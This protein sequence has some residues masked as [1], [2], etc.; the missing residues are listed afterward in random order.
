MTSNDATQPM[1]K[2]VQIDQRI[3]DAAM[4]AV[5]RERARQGG[6][7]E[8]G[9]QSIEEFTAGFTSPNVTSGYRV[10]IV[11]LDRAEDESPAN[12]SEKAAD[13]ARQPS[14]DEGTDVK[15]ETDEQETSG[16]DILVDESEETGSQTLEP[17]TQEQSGNE[18]RPEAA[19]LHPDEEGSPNLAPEEVN[20][21]FLDAF[22]AELQRCG[23]VD[24]V[25]SPGSRSTG[26][27]MKAY[28]RFHDVYVHVDER[29][30]AFFALG[31][32]KAKRRPV[33][34]ICTSGTAVGNWMP[35]VLEA[36]SSRVPL[37][38]LS[39]DRPA[40]LQH[41]GSPQTCDQL[42]MF[43]SHVR[44]FIQMPEPSADPTILSY[45]RQMA[46]EACIA[47]HGAVP[48]MQSC[49]AGPVHLNFPFDE[50][51]IPAAK[52][53]DD[54]AN[55]LPPTVVAGQ[56]LY[57]ADVKGIRKVLA[58]R[59]TIAL[60]GEGSINSPEDAEVLLEFARELHIPLIADP[61]S[62]LRSYGDPLVLDAYG[63]MDSN[64]IPAADVVIRFGRWP[65]SKM[66][67]R[68]LADQ[69][70]VHIAVDVRDTR[71]MTSSTSLFV[72]T[73]PVVFATA[74]RDASSE[75]AADEAGCAEWVEANERA[76][77]RI[78][79]SIRPQRDDFEGAYVAKTLELAPE[80]SLVFCANSMS[81]R[82][83]DR[84]YRKGGKNLRVLCNRGLNGIDGTLSSAIGAS[85]AYR[86]ATF[87]TGDLALLHDVNA[88]AFQNELRVREMHGGGL[89]P[90]LVVVL[91]NNN[92]GG[93]FD[94]LPQKSQE[95]HFARLF[96]TPQNV[97]FKQIAQG[98]GVPYE[99]AR[100]IA[101]FRTAY[102]NAIAQPGVSLIEVPVP[103]AGVTERYALQ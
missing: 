12:R 55:P 18:L 14:R 15:T 9:G 39:G 96:L 31:L 21:A 65:V 28:E 97:N 73:L 62:G 25:I 43:G 103:L 35:A 4:R 16:L 23:V 2:S 47:A 54:D 58:G 10:P 37:L 99:R 49:D 56:G 40:R 7:F 46:L 85:Q 6:V 45:A 51:L 34:V 84:Y 30:A 76:A 74:L 77:D 52:T 64:E 83:L 63:G 60:C 91:L 19:V 48:G 90:T 3:I 61:L 78:N 57:P 42:N 41:V 8:R 11:S 68:V 38:F 81:I 66:L 92:G 26:L 33:A 82:A 89:A 22:F 98:F 87:I 1:H 79:A 86:Q 71:D 29:G 75:L 36:E 70:P 24:Y 72:H 102:Q 94:M 93:I 53:R 20:A 44:K 95:G 67:T 69:H 100:T 59:R 101:G 32:A 88:F 50:P 17:A 80:D 27:A 5:Q 13:A